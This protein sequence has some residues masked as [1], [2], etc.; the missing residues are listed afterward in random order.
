MFSIALIEA[1]AGRDR[2]IR[3]M[4][5]LKRVADKYNV[6]SRCETLLQGWVDEWGKKHP[7]EFKL[8]QE[9]ERVNNAIGVAK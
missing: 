2:H 8:L 3:E 1:V 7:H 6:P 9:R 5:E 4:L